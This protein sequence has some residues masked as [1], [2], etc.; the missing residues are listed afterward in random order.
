MPRFNMSDF[1]G[2]EPKVGDWI[3]MRVSSISKN[4]KDMPATV[5]CDYKTITVL[6]EAPK[7]PSEKKSTPMPFSAPVRFAMNEKPVT[8]EE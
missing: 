2:K 1:N 3:G 6:P 8:R 5:E 7:F 4:D